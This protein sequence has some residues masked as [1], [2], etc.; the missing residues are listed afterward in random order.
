MYYLADELFGAVGEC[1]CNCA[2]MFIMTPENCLLQSFLIMRVHPLRVSHDHGDSIGN[3]NFIDFQV[4]VRTDNGSPRKVDPLTTEIA[5]KTTLFAFQPLRE[6]SL[7]FSVG[8][9]R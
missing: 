8:L 7:G 9:I 6:T 4:G 5:T 1:D 3:S 2:R